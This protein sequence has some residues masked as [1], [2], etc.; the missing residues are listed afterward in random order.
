SVRAGFPATVLDFVTCVGRA[1]ASKQSLPAHALPTSQ[2]KFTP[3]WLMT[4]CFCGRSQDDE[5]GSLHIRGFVP[6]EAGKFWPTASAV[7]TYV[8]S[9]VRKMLLAPPPCSV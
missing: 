1:K 9:A 8:C 3:C 6:T 7:V 2:L 4:D 5:S